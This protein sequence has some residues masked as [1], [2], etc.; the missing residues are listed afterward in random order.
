M[1]GW[2]CNYGKCLQRAFEVAI[3]YS[4]YTLKD[5]KD[6][7]KLHFDVKLLATGKRDR[8]LA[9]KYEQAE[10]IQ[11]EDKK[12]TT[13]LT[14]KRNTTKKKTK[15]PQQ[16]GMKSVKKKP[17]F[18]IYWMFVSAISVITLFLIIALLIIK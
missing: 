5:S 3:N 2:V 7:L 18:S 8:S 13:T 1:K 9:K 15:L 6:N 11:K 10:K 4:V 16:S 17:K 12:S 14:K